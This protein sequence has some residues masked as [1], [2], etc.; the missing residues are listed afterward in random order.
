MLNRREFSQRLGLGA[1]MAAFAPAMRGCGT[2][3][4][5]SGGE[6][7]DG[8]RRAVVIDCDGRLIML[9]SVRPQTETVHFIGCHDAGSWG[10]EDAH[11]GRYI[12]RYT[13]H[14]SGDVAVFMCDDELVS[15]VAIHANRAMGRSVV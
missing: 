13:G 6:G 2:G 7:A 8:S 14:D 3:G 12:A 1:I 10:T 11:Y 4:Q 9:C 5:D 15:R